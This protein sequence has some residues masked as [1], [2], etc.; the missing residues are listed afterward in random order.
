MPL[1]EGLVLPKKNFADDRASLGTT[2]K[3]TAKT[4]F[5]KKREG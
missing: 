5:A 2:A 1:A 4:F 3:K